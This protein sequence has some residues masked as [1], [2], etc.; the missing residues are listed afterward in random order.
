MMASQ[1][2]PLRVGEILDV[3]LKIYLKNASPL[4]KLVLIFVAP[5]QALAVLVAASTTP[6]AISDISTSPPLQP[7]EVP[8]VEPRE[9]WTFFAAN[10][11]VAL[12]GLVMVLLATAACFKAISDSYLGEPVDWRRSLRFAGRRTASLVWLALLSFMLLGLAVVALV[13]PAIWLWVA[14]SVAVPVLL[15]EGIK[16]RR[17][18]GR[19]YRLV[20][21]RWWPT[22]GAL[23]VGFLL[24]GIVTTIVQFAL[25]AITFTDVAD[26][27]FPSLVVNGVSAT[28]G[29]L[30]STPFQAALVVVIYFDLRVRKEAFDLEILA[31]TLGV[32]PTG[33]RPD[34]LPDPPVEA[35]T[36]PP[37]WPPPPGWDSSPPSSP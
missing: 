19:S 32:T 22:F 12:I 14:W 16:G 33:E 7:G 35:G 2:R 11:V 4:M 34:F 25:Q 27:F 31:G 24:A 37:Y 9:V 30:I 28:V 18:L 1:L 8:E 26:D 21:G 23:L 29:S 15:F 3:A 13:I 20:K 6:E 17:A 36:Q 5:F 10:G